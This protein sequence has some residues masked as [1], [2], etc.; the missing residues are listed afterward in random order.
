MRICYESVCL[1]AVMAEGT[2]KIIPRR[3]L[4]RKDELSKVLLM[5]MLVHP[6]VRELTR[7]MVFRRGIV[8]HPWAEGCPRCDGRLSSALG[9]NAPW[10][11]LRLELAR[12][13]VM[14]KW[15]WAECDPHDEGRS[16]NALGG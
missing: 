8:R 12:R 16:S 11:S 2:M 3:G 5:R 7:T 14:K 13:F 6:A 4:G 15:P 1:R 9:G 10:G